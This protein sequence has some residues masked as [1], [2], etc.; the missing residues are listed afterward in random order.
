MAFTSPP[1]P[2][3]P[4]AISSAAAM[5]FTA[6]RVQVVMNTGMMLTESALTNAVGGGV[7]WNVLEN[8]LE[9]LVETY[10]KVA[11]PNKSTAAAAAGNKKSKGKKEKKQKKKNKTSWWKRLFRGA[12]GGKSGGGGDGGGD[13][14]GAAS[15][16]KTVEGTPPGAPAH[17]KGKA[18]F[19]VHGTKGLSYEVGEVRVQGSS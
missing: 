15:R 16:W 6:K 2:V 7:V 17:V 18:A 8:S 4:P 9:K 12:G 19:M 1:L 3:P 5:F 11:L 10:G 13:G 14:A